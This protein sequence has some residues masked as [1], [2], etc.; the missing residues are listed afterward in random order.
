LNKYRVASRGDEGL[1]LTAEPRAEAKQFALEGKA[2]ENA[3]RKKDSKDQGEEVSISDAHYRMVRNKPLL[4]VHSLDPKGKQVQ[5]P[6][7]AF[8]ISFPYGDSETIKA[9]VNIVWLRQMQGY[10]DNPDDEED[11]DD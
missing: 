3:R 8:G 1:G 10:G 11:Y 5:G 6:V 7:A 9:V 2:E 4:M